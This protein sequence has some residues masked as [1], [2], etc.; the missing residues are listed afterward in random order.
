MLEWVRRKVCFLQYASMRMMLNFEAIDACRKLLKDNYELLKSQVDELLTTELK[1]LAEVEQCLREEICTAMDNIQAHIVDRTY[2]PNT[3]ITRAV[4]EYRDLEDSESLKFFD[5]D[6]L[7]VGMENEPKLGVKWECR[8]TRDRRLN[9]IWREVGLITII[10][11]RSSCM[12]WYTPVSRQSKKVMLG[13]TIPNLT[14][15]IW[16]SLPSGNVLT[17]GFNPEGCT[18]SKEVLEVSQTGKI[19][20][21]PNLLYPRYGPAGIYYDGW[22]YCFGG[23]HNS[24]LAICE[25]SSLSD[26]IWTSMPNMAVARHYFNAHAYKGLIYLIGGNTVENEVYSPA[27]GAFSSLTFKLIE[28]SCTMSILHNDELL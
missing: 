16:L 4:F 28:S 3:D 1:L 5:F 10:Y 23:K 8:L 17:F 27:S 22:V 9:L 25:K 11:L 19:A 26:K 21:Y 24:P 15:A 7:A 18:G 6:K 13:G 14:Y 12:I 20:F 2:V